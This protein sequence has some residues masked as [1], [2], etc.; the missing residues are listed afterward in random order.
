MYNRSMRKFFLI[1]LLS[2]GL[3]TTSYGSYLDDWPD[4]SICSWLKQ[5][6]THEGY[7]GQAKKRGLSCGGEVAIKPST[8]A[9]VEDAETIQIEPAELEMTSRLVGEFNL[10]QLSENLNPNLGVLSTLIG[11]VDINQDGYDDFV[12]GNAAFDN[13][14]R[15]AVNEF[16][17]PVFLFWNNSIKEYVVDGDVQKGLP[18]MY[19]PH[20]VHSSVNPKNGLTYLFVTDTGHDLANYDY[21]KGMNNL[22]PN[23]GAQNRLFTY[24]PSSGGVEEVQLP[25]LNDYSHGL[26]AGDMNGDQVTDY[27][28]LNINAIGFPEK[29]LF[30]GEEYTNESY[31]LYS[32]KKGGFDKVDLKLNYKKATHDRRKK[33]HPAGTVAVDSNNDVYLILGSTHFSD[34]IYAFKQDSKASFT[35]TSQVS[36]PEFMR[37]DGASASHAEV[38]YADIDADGVKE[39]VSGIVNSKHDGRYVQLLDFSNGQLT[40]RSH[41]LVQSLSDASKGKDWCVDLFFNEQTAWNQPILTC[42]HMRAPASKNRGSFFTWTEGK[43]QLAKIKSDSLSDWTRRFYP[44]TLGQKT[45]F[46]GHEIQGKRLIEGRALFDSIHLYLIQPPKEKLPPSNTFDGN[47]YFKLIITHSDGRFF[48]PGGGLI[49][50]KNGILSVWNTRRVLRDVDSTIDKFDTFKGYIDENGDFQA[51]FEFNGCGPGD[52]QEELI[53]L[54]GNIHRDGQLFGDFLNKVVSFE[55]QKK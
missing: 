53:S 35:E 42:T 29:C 40:D 38:L 39:V 30:N 33:T 11:K 24:D 31:I 26:A 34:S 44:V 37:V 20:R 2:L 54:K 13:Q 52:C 3:T 7:L 55:L 43:L 15:N 1:I 48:S 17:K 19:F 28:V 49:E 12:V 4:D 21:S 32:N 25:Q 51:T 45:V 5:K 6:P 47:Y 9:S 8:A 41:D 18:F 27:V 14:H 50:I 23:C 46:V 22:P 36:A 16:S 10:K